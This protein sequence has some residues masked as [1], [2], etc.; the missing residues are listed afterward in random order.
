MKKLDIEQGKKYF[1]G[2]LVLAIIISIGVLI[3]NQAIEIEFDEK[4]NPILPDKHWYESQKQYLEK[5][6]DWQEKLLERQ[7]QDNFGGATP[8]ETLNSFIEALKQG[9]TEL[10]SRYFVFNKQAQMAE[11]LTIGK[12]NG[13]L[14]LLIVDLEKISGGN[15]YTGRNDMYEFVVIGEN[16]EWKGIVEFSFILVKN[17]QTQVWKIESL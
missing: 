10:A 3:K 12:E 15:F 5:V 7:S 11:E 8:E 6:V 16:G 13:V 1:I 17:Q 9:D 2:V 14:E 4:G